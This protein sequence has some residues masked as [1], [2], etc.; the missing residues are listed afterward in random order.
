MLGMTLFI[1]IHSFHYRSI[2]AT[3]AFFLNVKAFDAKREGVFTKTPW[4]LYQWKKA[5]T[6]LQVNALKVLSVFLR[7]SCHRDGNAWQDKHWSYQEYP[8]IHCL[9]LQVSLP[10][11]HNRYILQE[12]HELERQVRTRSL[13]VCFWEQFGQNPNRCKDGRRK[14]WYHPKHYRSCQQ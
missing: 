3:K 9:L 13:P 12:C 14:P 7:I 10:I 5:L 2:Y 1:C 6:S 4:R 11:C 8:R